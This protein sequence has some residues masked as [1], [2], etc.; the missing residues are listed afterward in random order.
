[1]SA[2]RLRIEL[3]GRVRVI[4]DGNALDRLP[5]QRV[6]ALLTYLV[7][8]RG[9]Q[10][11]EVVAEAIWPNLP[12]GKGL[13][14]LRKGLSLLRQ[15]LDEK[16][17]ESNRTH[18]RLSFS[19]FAS[20]VDEFLAKPAWLESYAGDLA[21]GLTDDWIEPIRENLRLSFVES[22]SKAAVGA[23]A[24][25]DYDEA[26]QLSERWKAS[27]PYAFEAQQHQSLALAHLG[28]IQSA[29]GYLDSWARDYR[30]A[31]GDAPELD[32]LKA[33]LKGI[34]SAEG[35]DSFPLYL[36]RYF[37]RETE[38][39]RIRDW[40]DSPSQLL[41]VF[42]MGGIGKTR[43]AVE[44][45]RAR[46]G[47]TYFV[48]LVAAE[49]KDAIV[50]AVIGVMGLRETDSLSG[51]ALLKSA[52]RKGR[53]LLVLDNLEQV[54]RGAGDFVL[55]LLAGN[56]EL[57]FLCTSREVLGIEG[58]ELLAL[59][60]LETHED[61]V[62]MFRDR[63]QNAR[64]GF[65]L[66]GDVSALCQELD[67]LPLAIELMA[68]WSGAWTVAQMRHN[69]HN[70]R[71][72]AR[73]RGHDPRHE[74]L[75]ASIEWSFNLLDPETRSFLSRLSI[76]R[77][78]WA[79]EAVRSILGDESAV[80]MQT[81]LVDRSLVMAS[82]SETGMRFDMLESVRFFCQSQLAGEDK[83]GLAPRFL[84]YFIQIADE[85][86][87][88][89][90]GVQE[91][92]NH[93]KLDRERDNF[94]A[95]VSMCEEGLALVDDGLALAGALY[96]HWNYRGQASVGIGLVD[97]LL[98]INDP[99]PPGRGRM[100]GLQALS[101]LAQERGLYDRA[102]D[103]VRQMEAVTGHIDDPEM[104]FRALTQAGN[105][106]NR[107]AMFVQ[108]LAPHLSALE[109]AE[110]VEHPRMVAVAQSNIAESLFGQGRREEAE[111]RWRK[112][113]ELD[114]ANGNIAGEAKLFLGF[115]QCLRGEYAEGAPHLRDYMLS[116]Q[117][118][119]Y[120]RGYVR[121]VQYTALVAW[122][123][124]ETGLAQ[125]LQT[126]AL[127]QVTREG[128]VY[129]ALERICANLVLAEISGEG[130]SMD[131]EIAVAR[132]AEFLTEVGSSGS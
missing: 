11:R 119:G 56:S 113:F 65:A 2:A 10:N 125:Q 25:G 29:L 18:V 58:E 100:H 23:L 14:N 32:S 28:R 99:N 54:V 128:I 5:T 39:K 86:T 94:E 69:V 77:G 131:I 40:A 101:V 122:R 59:S 123:L 52:L 38:L 61:A 97:R 34:E 70:G 44:A 12:D 13:V 89:C 51:S 47:K 8:Y 121:A 92:L 33:E 110:S 55:E 35:P 120:V 60:P 105:F 127:D 114:V 73:K 20:D 80:E 95:A 96:L 108:A 1:M 57:K 103:A 7:L 37:G 132:A 98:A 84:A 115:A 68:A 111:E 116:V 126:S 107:H 76:F 104:K 83:K 53:F 42:G 74:S 66:S 82:E 72:V 62:E 130:E 79:L 75:Q 41:T 27:S 17:I 19:A 31:I 90:V 91:R 15:S 129:D 45:I 124:G 88:P 93:L 3:L 30:A 24:A 21:P 85:Y 81:S 106:F 117:A 4:V 16:L 64:P 63:A 9:W 118:I 50:S 78:G 71:V 49:S 43:L 67:G 112:A 36:T 109:L 22:V 26:L 87:N 6:A 46:P 102:Q 48:P